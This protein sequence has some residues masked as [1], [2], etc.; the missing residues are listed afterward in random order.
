MA[1]MA[2]CGNC[3]CYLFRRSQQR[4]HY[5]G[6]SIL[7]EYPSVDI[8]ESTR[9]DGIMAVSSDLVGEIVRKAFSTTVGVRTG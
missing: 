6:L 7:F 2:T 8:R 4:A 5:I 3:F 9:C 1:L